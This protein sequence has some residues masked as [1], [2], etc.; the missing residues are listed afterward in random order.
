VN[1]PALDDTIVAVSTAWQAAP[2]GVIRLSGPDS[3]ALVVGLG[4]GPRPDAAGAWTAARVHLD[5]EHAVPAVACWFRGPRS[6]TGD[7]VVE[8]HVPGSPPLLRALLEKLVAAGARR[9]LPGEFT[10]RALRRHKLDTRQVQGVLALLE[11]NQAATLRQAARALC[12]RAADERNAVRERLLDLLARVEA[13]IDFVDEED[14]RFI[15]DEELRAGLDEVL[16]GLATPAAPGPR[17]AAWPHVALVGRPNAGKST[18]FNALVGADRALVS[19]VDG[20]TRDVLAADFDCEGI[21]CRLQDCAGLGR[22][23]DELERAAH[24]AAE[25]AAAQ[26]DVVL[27]VHPADEPWTREEVRAAATIAGGRGVL[28]LSKCDRITSGPTGRPELSAAFTA[29]LVVSALTGTGLAA[30]RR[31]LA[32]A[33]R[34]GGETPGIGVDEDARRAA[35][36][37]VQRARAAAAPEIIALELREAVS[38]LAPPA[39]APVD[40]DVL[41]RIFARF[42]I[43][44]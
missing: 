25:R 40:E 21:R 38:L 33:L 32:A 41:G 24:R 26:A 19:P 44:K 8:L 11:A 34:A 35:C 36:A 42:C 43:G 9:A 23:A 12:I 2:V 27:W 5:S 20:T 17:G 18:L 31:A 29:C 39:A 10:A 4:A 37:A 6:Y 1:L 30:L 14:V 22:T 7:D 28:V 13:G 16:A 15:S 3:F